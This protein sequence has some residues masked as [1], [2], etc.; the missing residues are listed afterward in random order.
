MNA[1]QTKWVE[2]L[3]SG[4]YEQCSGCLG[5]LLLFGRSL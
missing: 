3:E 1:L 4:D 2:A 5:W